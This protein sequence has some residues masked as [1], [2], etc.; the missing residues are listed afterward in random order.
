MT[1]RKQP[2][3]C[4][5]RTGRLFSTRRMNRLPITEMPVMGLFKTPGKIASSSKT[6]HRLQRC[7]SRHCGSGNEI[8][9]ISC[10]SSP[11]F[12]SF[13]V[14]NVTP[15]PGTSQDPS[16]P[17]L[18]YKAMKVVDTVSLLPPFLQTNLSR[19]LREF[20][21]SRFHD[22]FFDNDTPT[23]AWFSFFIWMELVYHVPLSVWAIF[24]LWK[25][26]SIYV[27]Y[28]HVWKV[29]RSNFRQMTQKSH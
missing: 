6:H 4:R 19:I 1:E 25:G 8:S 28:V 13:F 17:P 20:Y 15:D 7:Q 27:P 24:G 5:R 11:T 14:R 18:T 10:S 23:P 2:V 29:G 22:K 21:V 3:D 26:T 12:P 9:S 16:R